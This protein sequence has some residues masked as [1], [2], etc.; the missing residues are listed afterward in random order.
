MMSELG[1]EQLDET[2]FSRK[3]GANTGGLGIS[4]VTSPKHERPAAP[5]AVAARWRRTSCSAARR[6]RR[7]R[8]RSSSSPDRCSPRRARQPRAGHR[9]AQAVGRAHGVSRRRPPATASQARTS[10]AASRSTAR[11]P[12]CS[13][14]SSSSTRARERLK[15]A[16]DDWPSLLARLQRMRDELIAADGAIV[17]LSAD[18][19]RWPRHA[20]RRVAA[21]TQLPRRPAPAPGEPG[22]GWGMVGDLLVPVVRR[23]AGA[24]RST[25]W[26][27]RRRSTLRARRWAARR[28]SSRVTCAPPTCGMRCGCRRRVRLLAWASRASTAW[29][30]SRHTATRTSRRRAR[31]L[32]R[33][34]RLPS[35][36]SALDPAELSKAIIGAVGDLDSPQSV[37]AKAHQHG[38]PH[39][40]RHRGGAPGLAP[41]GARHHRRRLRRLCRPHRH[42]G[43]RRDRSRLPPSRRSARSQR[44][45]RRSRRPSASF[46]GRRFNSASSNSREQTGTGPRLK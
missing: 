35:C 21:L 4:T 39:A 9:D 23:S 38:A 18:G 17:N 16:E 26:P 6:R 44:R 24:P 19:A 31:Q 11:C 14:A 30:A 43:L 27:R 1:T 37:D 34:R 22:C 29:P 5:S 20:T 10:R 15:Q 12:S 2:S 46:R 32:R 8:L 45:T 3:V 42:R 28:R 25:T 7:R 40:R 13:V 36:E 41:S 33:H